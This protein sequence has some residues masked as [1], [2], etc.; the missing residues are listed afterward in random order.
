MQYTVGPLKTNTRQKGTDSQIDVTSTMTPI[1]ARL[2]VKCWP[3]HCYQQLH[4]YRQ[5]AHPQVLCRLS[6]RSRRE[7]QH[8]RHPAELVTE[9]H[10]HQSAHSY[11]MVQQLSLLGAHTTLAWPHR[12]RPSNTHPDTSPACNQIDQC[13]RKQHCCHVTIFNQHAL[14]RSRSHIDDARLPLPAGSSRDM[15]V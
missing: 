6:L 3:P 5:L 13:L 9:Q 14:H 2:V 1:K 10:D 12:Q 4:Q 7:A 8:S 11:L 15:L